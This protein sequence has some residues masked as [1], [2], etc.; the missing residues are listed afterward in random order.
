MKILENLGVIAAK[1]FDEIIIRCDK[2]LRGRTVEEIIQLLEEGINLHYSDLPVHVIPN[3]TEALNFAYTNSAE[4]ALVTVMCDS[5]VGTL[6][7]IKEIKAK[8]EEVMQTTT[9]SFI[10]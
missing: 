2:N 5:V 10:P 8:E 1:Y 4:G 7:K 9:F 3:E 6:D